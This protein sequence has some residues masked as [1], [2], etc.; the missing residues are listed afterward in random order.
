MRRTSGRRLIL[1][2]VLI[3]VVVPLTI[4]FGMTFLRD[5]SYW[6]ISA[7][8]LVEATLPFFLAFARR[9]PKAREIVLICSLAAIAVIGR[10]A[11][12]MLPQFKPVSAVVIVSAV[13]LGPESGFLVGALAGFV[14]NFFFGQGPWTPW[15]MFS[16][17]VI[18]FLA[19][20]LFF[21]GKIRKPSKTEV[22]VYG[23]LSTF[24]IYGGLMNFY[25]VLA[26]STAVTKESVAAV[27]LSGVPFD[28]IHAGSTVLFLFLIEK[29]M[30]EKITRM[31][32]KYGLIDESERLAEARSR[33]RSG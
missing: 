23:G 17:G 24:L 1:S 33:F 31:R 19:G 14:S 22:C 5:R 25:S 13:G 21:R 9:R 32:V 11:F 18:G 28:L 20:L 15:Q 3:L 30:A 7:A 16:F 12:F 26:F 4:A 27:Y 8:I 10:C 6:F 2:C 29:P